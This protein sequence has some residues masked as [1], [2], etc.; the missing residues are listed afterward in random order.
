MKTSLTALAAASYLLVTGGVSAVPDQHLVVLDD[1]DG[2]AASATWTFS[3]GPEF[4]GA[5]GSFS[6][7]DG[8]GR[9][10]SK[11]GRLSFDFTGGG[12]YVAAEATL[13]APRSATGARFWLKKNS[14]NRIVVRCSDSSGQTFQKG[15]AYQNPDWQE[16]HASFD[17]WDVHWGGANDGAYNGQIR[18]LAI[19]VENDAE[20]KGTLLIDDVRL[21]QQEPA[22]RPPD[23]P[24][25]AASFDPHE[26]WGVGSVG[27]RGQSGMKD[28]VLSL[29]WSAGASE[30]NLNNDL[31]ILG[32]PATLSLKLNSEA[33]GTRVVVKIGSHFQIFERE[34]GVLGSGQ[35]TLTAPMGGM[36]EW[37]HYGGENDGIPQYPLRIL[38]I[39]FCRGQGSASGGNVE[40]ISAEADTS[41][42]PLQAVVM[43]P[44]GRAGAKASTFGLELR[45]VTSAPVSGVL[46]AVIRNWNG[47]VLD[48]REHA[49][50]IG[51][52]QLAAHEFSFSSQQSPYLECEMRFVTP[53]RTY[54]PAVAYAVQPV[55]EPGST[56][57]VPSSPFGMGLYLYRYPGDE[58]GLKMMD[59]A[60]EMGSRAGVKWSREEFQ[61][62]RIEP[63]RGKFDFSYYDK[64]V[65]TAN[66]HGISVYGIIAYWSGW[67]KQYTQEGV[68]DYADYCR[69]LV[70]HY[71]DRIKHW[72]VWNEPNIFFWTGPKELY[73]DLLKQAYKAIKEA[74]PEALV[75]GCSTSGIDREF[76]SR[77][78]ADGAPFDILTIHPYRGHLDERGFIRELQEAAVLAGD[79]KGKTKPT[80]ITEMGLPTQLYGGLSERNQ[81]LF[82]ARCYLSA[83]ASGIDTNISWY[84]FREDGRNPF[85]N[86][87]RF[88]VVRHDDLA[89]KPAY[90][91]LATICRT[92]GVPRLKGEIKMGDGVICH[93][94]TTN[95]GQDVAA[96]WS[97]GSDRLVSLSVADPQ[98]DI[99]DLMGGKPPA[100]RAGRE[101]ILAL[102][103]N[104]P[105]LIRGRNLKLASKAAPLQV[106]APPVVH[107][108]QTVTVRF[109]KSSAL[110]R[111]RVEIDAPEG[112]T[113]KTF[114][115][116]CELMAP[117]SQPAGRAEM[118]ACITLEGSTLRLPYG[119]EVSA[120]VIRI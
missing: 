33:P 28:K 76:I 41:I 10:K 11:A 18:Y 111:A 79:S 116:R 29:D 47:E 78:I 103:S 17:S 87:H 44:S 70:T 12:N 20:R 40:L 74:D 115:D 85:Y 37:Q 99:I 36:T 100:L 110:A 51:Q 58:E 62:H 80:W 3:D 108:G 113:R 105:L 15:F 119:L 95:T 53:G 77:V 25:A 6:D 56:E 55:T 35:Q 21:T 102:R 61:W 8:G 93:L 1:F 107:P 73:S 96:M 26:G 30:I 64:M 114:E 4:P 117:A 69:A 67:T 39:S 94:Y 23:N 42:N 83:L 57:L 9:Q 120:A 19:I 91:A 104:T 81:A 109:K 38:Q 50:R 7:R 46:H 13:D 72:E 66:R 71:K 97:M 68:Q 118:Q 90:R 31:A 2:Q 106:Q 63:E 75:L 34:M 82:L 48:R 32:T 59:R 5:R 52:G 60:A 27:A 43:V 89:P 92:L 16:V 22:K 54:G 86:E 112:W 65:E 45:N 84:D 14:R 98:A 24:Y 88:G 101:R 49:L